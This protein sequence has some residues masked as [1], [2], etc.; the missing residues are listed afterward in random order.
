MPEAQPSQSDS[1]YPPY[2]QPPQPYRQP[3]PYPQRQPPYRPRHYSQQPQPSVQPQPGPQYPPYRQPQP[4]PMFTPRPP[5]QPSGLAETRPQ[6]IPQPQPSP[7][8]TPLTR[9]EIPPPQPGPEPPR[10]TREQ[11]MARWAIAGFGV[12]VLVGIIAGV[13]SSGGG[14]AGASAP[15]CY[16]TV[17]SPQGSSVTVATQGMSDCT[18]VAPFLR[19]QFVT[20][21]VIPNAPEGPGNAVCQGMLGGVY[22]ST[23]IDPTGNPEGV[24]CLYLGFSPAP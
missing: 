1:H 19:E 24:E 6:A 17:T 4:G 10:F 20:Y 7:G 9:E 13:A 16:S 3:E 2:Q 11:L 23:V 12:I 22:P 15:H 18:S 14:G 21:T 5:A 8:G